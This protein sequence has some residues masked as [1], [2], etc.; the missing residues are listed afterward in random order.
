M[1]IKRNLSVPTGN[2]LISKGEKGR[3]L[4]FLSIGDYGKGQ[5]V[6]ASF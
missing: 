1:E 5:N 4:E 3:D 6:K 2:I